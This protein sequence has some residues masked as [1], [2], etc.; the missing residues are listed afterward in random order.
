MPIYLLDNRI[1]FPSIEHTEDG[2]LAIGGD[3]SIERLLLAYENG[4]FPWYNEGEPIVWHSPDERFILL[5][6]DLHISKSMRRTLNSNKFNYTIN[7]HFSFVINQCA[8]VKRNDHDGTW[9]TQEMIDA[10]T[11]LHHKGYAHSIEVWQHDKIVGGLYGVSLGKVFFAESMFH[12]V[13]NASKFAFIKLVELL[14]AKDFL[15]MDAQV[16][17]EHIETLGAKLISKKTFMVLLHKALDKKYAKQT[18]DW[19]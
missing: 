2:I 8:S 5:L 15:F 16:Y 10:Y 9:L 4:I 13:T 12:T 7:A 3:L 17:S 1:I 11:L 18:I 19:K 14:K 6:D